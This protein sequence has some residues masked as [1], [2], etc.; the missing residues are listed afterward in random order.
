MRLIVHYFEPCDMMYA[1]YRR[2]SL[3][4]D[5]KG[6]LSPNK[7]LQYRAYSSFWLSFLYVVVVGVNDQRIVHALKPWAQEGPDIRIYTAST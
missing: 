1:C 7:R 4:W 3:E 5:N 6:K 2:L